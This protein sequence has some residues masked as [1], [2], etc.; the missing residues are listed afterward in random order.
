MAGIT[1]NNAMQV[2]LANSG[3]DILPFLPQNS[4]KGWD[5]SLKGTLGS[6]A[7]REG[8]SLCRH[9]L[10]ISSVTYLTHKPESVAMTLGN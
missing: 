10:S 4:T 3:L 2:P 7:R 5:S 9:Q 1:G 6:A 8:W